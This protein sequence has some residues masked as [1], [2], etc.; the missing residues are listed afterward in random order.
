MDL[1]SSMNIVCLFSDFYCRGVSHGFG[2]FHI[3]DD[4]GFIF[5]YDSFTFTKIFVG[6]DDL[7]SSLSLQ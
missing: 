1:L 2:G 4:L 3:S 5:G 7:A 6:F